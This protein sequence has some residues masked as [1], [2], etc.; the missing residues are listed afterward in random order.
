MD[1]RLIVWQR[2]SVAPSIGPIIGGVL[3]HVAGWT[4][5]FWFLC[6]AAGLCLAFMAFMLPETSRGIVGNGS[7][8]PPKYLRLPHEVAMC[9]WKRDRVSLDC[10]RKIP[11]PLKSLKILF[12]KDNATI[13]TACGLTYVVYT[14]INASLSILFIRIYHLNQWQAGLVYLPFGVGGTVSTFFSGALLNAAYRNARTELGLLTDNAGGDDLDTFPIEKARLRV[15]WIP[16]VVTIGSVVIY[17]WALHY[18]RVS[19]PCP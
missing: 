19:S 5:I 17:G 11:N 10:K 8:A 15:M 18:S 14:C 3:S 12:R 6:I 1:A 16:M 9:H 4:W 2:I 13:I 7:I